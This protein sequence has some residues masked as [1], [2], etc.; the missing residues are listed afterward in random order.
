M[1][2]IF[3]PEQRALTDKMLKK[4]Y[5]AI[6]TRA[7]KPREE[8]SKFMHAHLTHQIDL[9]KRGIMFG[10]GPLA[11]PDGSLAGFGLIIVRAESEAEARAIADS[12]PM[13]SNGMRT[14]TLHQWILNEGR[15]NITLN[16]SDQTYSLN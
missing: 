13:H 1:Q 11:D 3:P 12:D 4:R 10:A 16:F 8:I 9:E 5:W 14:Y 6:L 2:P 15:I 7:A